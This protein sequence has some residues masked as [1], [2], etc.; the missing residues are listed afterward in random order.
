MNV[1]HFSLSVELLKLKGALSGLIQFLATESP[2]KVLFATFL[3]F[4]LYA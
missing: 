1:S 2:L 3:R 4:A